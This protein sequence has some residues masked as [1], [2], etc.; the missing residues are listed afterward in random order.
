MGVAHP[1]VASPGP[2]ANADALHEIDLADLAEQARNGTLRRIVYSGI[3][4][5]MANFM[6]AQSCRNMFQ[7]SATPPFRFGDEHL[8]CPLGSRGHRGRNRP[9]PSA[10]AGGVL[11]RDRR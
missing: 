7:S 10:D 2:V 6:P 1:P 5:H 4:L 8:V 9:V 3:G 11:S